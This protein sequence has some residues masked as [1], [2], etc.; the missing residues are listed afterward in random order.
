MCALV[1][2]QQLPLAFIVSLPVKDGDSPLVWKRLPEGKTGLVLNQIH[3]I[4]LWGGHVLDRST[5]P[6]GNPTVKSIPFKEKP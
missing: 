3:Q 5:E 6:R 2:H 1:N 4:Y